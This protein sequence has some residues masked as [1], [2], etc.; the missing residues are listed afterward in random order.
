M[1]SDEQE[2][3]KLISNVHQIASMALPII[4]SLSPRAAGSSPGWDHICAASPGTHLAH[5]HSNHH[6]L[7]SDAC[8]EE[9]QNQNSAPYY[10]CHLLHPSS[11][12]TFFLPI[13]YEV[14]TDKAEFMPNSYPRAKSL[15]FSP[16]STSSNPHSKTGS[17]FRPTPSVKKK[18]EITHTDFSPPSK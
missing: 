3:E 17:L 7:S 12:L 1:H 9:W 14:D 16:N 8:E 11:C 2:E 13:L 10:L 15:R 5:N 18:T 6:L 4:A